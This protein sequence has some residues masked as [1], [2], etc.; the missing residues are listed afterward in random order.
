MY[1]Y[2]K[3]TTYENK[4]S[5]YKLLSFFFKKFTLSEIKLRFFGIKLI[6]IFFLSGE[7]IFETARREV[8]EE[9]G[10][11]TEFVGIISFRHQ[12]NY[13]YGCGDFYF[14]CVM[15]PANNDQTINMCTQEIADC[16]WV[17][18][19]TFCCVFYNHI[20]FCLFMVL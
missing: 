8:V 4:K 12:Q 3:L 18:V 11:E 19:S 6:L 17:N 13:R 7:N 5:F 16:K 14:I 9:T 15:R 20:K 2:F 10:I 1:K